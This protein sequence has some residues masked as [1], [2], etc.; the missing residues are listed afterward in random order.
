MHCEHTSAG[1]H[2]VALIFEAAKVLQ[3]WSR[4]H[5]SDPRRSKVLGQ[6]IAQR[7]VLVPIVTPLRRVGGR[8]HAPLDKGGDRGGGANVPCQRCRHQLYPAHGKRHWR[9]RPGRRTTVFEERRPP[10]GAAPW[11]PGEAALREA[12]GVVA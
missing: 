3:P 11:R 1:I 4:V 5:V 10:I 7:H 6:P 12:R 9:V 8:A 2:V